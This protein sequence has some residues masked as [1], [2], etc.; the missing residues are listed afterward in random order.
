MLR[1]SVC[2]RLCLDVCL[3]VYVKPQCSGNASLLKVT[4][5]DSGGPVLAGWGD[6][7]P[8]ASWGFWE[9]CKESF[10]FTSHPN[11]QNSGSVAVPTVFSEAAVLKVLTWV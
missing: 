4:F 3:C 1:V 8:H 2:V 11:F 7:A 9:V 10:L 6:I 5:L